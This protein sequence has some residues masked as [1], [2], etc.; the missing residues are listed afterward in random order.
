MIKIEWAA[1]FFALIL[2]IGFSMVIKNSPRFSSLF[3]K[4]Y[5]SE[6]YDLINADLRQ[7]YSFKLSPLE[8]KISFNDLFLQT[9]LN[10]S[11]FDSKPIILLVGQYSVGKT[12]FI[13]YLLKSDYPGIQFGTEQPANESFIAVMYNPIKQLLSGS[14]SDNQVSFLDLS[15]FGNEF[16]DNKFKYSLLPND[17]LKNIVFIDTPGFLRNDQLLNLDRGYNFTAVL[18]WFTARSDRIYLMFDSNC[19]NI[20]MDLKQNIHLFRSSTTNKLRIILNKADLIDHYKLIQIYG[21]LMWNLGHLL[22]TDHVS[23]SFIGSFRQQK[24]SYYDSFRRDLF[25][26]NTK[27]LLNDIQSLPQDLILKKINYL[28]KRSR[29]VK[30]CILILIELKKFTQH[31]K[32]IDFISKIDQFFNVSKYFQINKFLLLIIF[33]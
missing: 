29:A 11:Y 25:K 23:K 21:D 10:D 30:L 28:I 4:S 8:T 32:R 18:N 2:L 26:K 33:Y 13:R 1:S 3:T 5:T 14:S 27:F 16:L 9:K 6:H 31:D 17:I 20:S 19:Y 7:L 22:G 12:S 24:S 15:Q